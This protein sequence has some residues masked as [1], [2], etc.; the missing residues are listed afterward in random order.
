MLF[1]LKSTTAQTVLS[2]TN[3]N[4]TIRSDS[5]TV[6]LARYQLTGVAISGSAWQSHRVFFKFGDKGIEY[7]QLGST[8]QA[9]LG[10]DNQEKPSRRRKNPSQRDCFRVCAH[11]TR[12]RQADVH[13]ENQG[14][15]LTCK[16]TL[17][18][19]N[20]VT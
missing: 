8:G 1:F 4:E 16:E 18:H 9:L 13:E 11:Y 2:S 19:R 12:S 14:N 5:R 10:L 6:T 20:W 15:L 7:V 3:S 17:N